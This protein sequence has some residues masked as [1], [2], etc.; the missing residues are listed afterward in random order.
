M[1]TEHSPFIIVVY[2]IYRN[3]LMVTYKRFAT[4][5]DFLAVIINYVER[6]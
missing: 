3:K 4:R 1:M 6:H 2:E 5:D